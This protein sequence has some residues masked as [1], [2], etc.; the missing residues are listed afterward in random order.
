[1]KNDP[2]GTVFQQGNIMRIDSA[3][4]EDVSAPNMPNGFLL[5]SYAVT[6]PNN[7]VSIQ[8]LRLN[9]HRNTIILNSFGQNMCLCSIRKGM[10][11]SAVFSSR[12]TRSIPPQSTA[13]LIIVRREPQASFDITIDR[14]ASINV[15]NQVLHTGNPGNINSQI[16]FIITDDTTITG[17]NGR[18]V[19]LRA[20]RPGQMVRITHSI[21]QTTS[22]PPQT[23][24]FHIQLL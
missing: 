8:N 15:R 12:M 17:R 4:V 9:V 16:R 2:R 14:I 18:P 6:G 10:W 21:V 5:I 1:M 24:A 13:F 20:L 11:V 23:V 22:V 7:T 3:L 19:D